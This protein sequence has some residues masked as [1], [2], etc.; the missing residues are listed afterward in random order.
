[1][2]SMRD[3]R[4]AMRG[5]KASQSCHCQENE[6]DRG[7][8]WEKVESEAI[9]QGGHQARRDLMADTAIN[10]LCDE[11][12]LL[13]YLQGDRPIC[14]KVSVRPVEEPE[15]GHQAQHTGDERT[16]AQCVLGE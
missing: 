7:D 15:A 1:M 13:A 10:A 2:G 14:A 4:C 16:A 8:S 3:A 12:M 11:S 6:R 9:E 5:N